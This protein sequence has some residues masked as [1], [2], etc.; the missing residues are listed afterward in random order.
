S[1]LSQLV[2]EYH[3][4][5][6]SGEINSAVDDVAGATKRVL[7][8]LS[9]YPGVEIDDLDGLFVDHWDQSPKWWVSLRVSNTEPLLR[10]NV[11][12]ETA[13]VMT[14]IRDEVLALVRGEDA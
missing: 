9:Q 11:E 5:V 3:P 4:Y 7:A 12:A 1:S 13:P 10:L 2:A 6:A 14:K 8:H